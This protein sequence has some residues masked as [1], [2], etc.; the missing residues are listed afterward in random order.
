MAVGYSPPLSILEVQSYI[1]L[2][3]SLCA[4]ELEEKTWGCSYTQSGWASAGCKGDPLLPSLPPVRSPQ[5]IAAVGIPTCGAADSPQPAAPY[6]PGGP[7]TPRLLHGLSPSLQTFPLAPGHPKPF[8]DPWYMCRCVAYFLIPIAPS[9]L[10][11]TISPQVEPVMMMG[12]CCYSTWSITASH[13]GGI[14]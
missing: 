3:T 2:F 1:L 11:G 4:K 10:L 14:M 12:G 6:S 13:V 7:P 5:C 8:L 9:P